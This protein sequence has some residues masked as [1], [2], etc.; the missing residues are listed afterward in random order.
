MIISSSVHIYNLCTD[1]E[2]EKIKENY[3]PVLFSGG[4]WWRRGDDGRLVS[5]L[6][7]RL[8]LT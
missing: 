4:E 5:V 8:L 1:I 2:L 6:D 7:W 3:G